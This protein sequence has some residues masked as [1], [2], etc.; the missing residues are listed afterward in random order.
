[1][2][3]KSYSSHL[4]KLRP[5]W[6]SS[7]PVLSVLDSGKHHF[8]FDF[9]RSTFRMSTYKKNT[10]SI[11]LCLARC[12]WCH[13]PYFHQCC[14]QWQDFIHLLV[15]NL[16]CVS[17]TF[18]LSTY[19]PT[20]TCFYFLEWVHNAAE[21]AGGQL[22][23]KQAEER[24]WRVTAGPSGLLH[25]GQLGV[26]PPIACE[27]PLCHILASTCHHPSWI[28]LL[29]WCGGIYCGFDFCFYNGFLYFLL[30][31]FCFM[32]NLFPESSKGPPLISDNET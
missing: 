5:H 31:N 29:W 3:T 25:T 21:S 19:L 8:T 17:S 11:F 26:P 13:V 23:P 18:H 6:T 22:S 24:G 10:E 15:S 7:L 14:C 16:L 20:D 1:M 32:A 2:H 12:I 30:K 28:Q 9:A 27:F 4:N